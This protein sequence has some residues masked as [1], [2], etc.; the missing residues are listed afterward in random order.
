MPVKRCIA[1]NAKADRPIPGTA[2]YLIVS[3]LSNKPLKITSS[4]IGAKITRYIKRLAFPTS[5]RVSTCGVS[6]MKVI[7]DN[8]PDVKATHD[9][10][11]AMMSP[12]LSE[13]FIGPINL[14]KDTLFPSRLIAI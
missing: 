14:L 11:I 13:A 10:E 4:I 3:L 7:T 12:Q 6:N 1:I 8:V 9:I 5:N 2:P